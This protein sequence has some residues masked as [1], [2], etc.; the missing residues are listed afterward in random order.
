[1]VQDMSG[2]RTETKGAGLPV[3]VTPAPPRARLAD[4][5]RPAAAFLSQLIAARHH[6]EPQRARRRAPVTAA[7][8]AYRIGASVAVRRLPAGYRRTIVA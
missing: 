8:D 2:N 7:V 4:R 1:M 3:V 6:L 5:G